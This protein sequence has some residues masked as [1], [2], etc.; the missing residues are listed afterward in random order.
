MTSDGDRPLLAGTVASERQL[1]GI[2]NCMT[3]SSGALGGSAVKPRP[4]PVALIMR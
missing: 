3:G 2:V 4:N 1:T